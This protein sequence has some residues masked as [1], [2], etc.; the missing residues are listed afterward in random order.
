VWHGEAHALRQLPDDDDSLKTLDVEKPWHQK[1]VV[2][3]GICD[4]KYKRDEPRG[5]RVKVL[6]LGDGRFSR[7]SGHG[8]IIKTNFERCYS[9][10]NMLDRRL[11]VGNKK[12]TH[13]AFHLCGYKQ[14][15]P[16]Q[17]CFRRDYTRDLHTQIAKALGISD[18]GNAEVVL[19]LLNRC[20]GAGVIVSRTGSELDSN[21][22]M[23][24]EPP[25]GFSCDVADQFTERQLD[26]A[27]SSVANSMREHCLHWW[28]NECPVFIA[29][30]CA[31]SHPVAKEDSCKLY[32]GTL[33]VGFVLLGSRHGKSSCAHGV[34]SGGFWKPAASNLDIEFLGGYWKLPSESISSSD[35][36]GRCVSKAKTGTETVDGVDLED[37][38]NVLRQPLLDVFSVTPG[39]DFAQAYSEDPLLESFMVAR[40]AAATPHYKQL[41]EMKLP[42]QDMLTPDSGKSCNDSIACKAVASH[43]ERQ[44]GC[45]AAC[46]GDWNSAVEKWETSIS[47]YSFNAT[48]EHLLGYYHLSNA[49]YSKAI[50]H[51]VRSLSLD[52]E[53][54]ATYVNLSGTF[55]VARKFG[56]AV[57]VAEVGLTRYPF[58]YQ[59]SYNL[60]IALVWQLRLEL[61]EKD[62]PLSVEWQDRKEELFLEWVGKARRATE[63]L[64]AARDQKESK[65]SS[66]LSH[67]DEIL[68]TLHKLV[69]RLQ[70]KQRFDTVVGMLQDL[71]TIAGWNLMSFRP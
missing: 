64:V 12:V 31:V 28:T 5:C 36:A 40:L 61:Q 33:R 58:A 62:W 38:Y 14:L 41:A 3:F 65:Q 35:I 26:K 13:D 68:T 55:L 19:K 21:L 47:Y 71:P 6:E 46:K 23:L 25:E 69:E 45:A 16:T 30:C 10:G 44:L 54:K 49:N 4:L 27:L 50:K 60:G 63:A 59:C 34:S 37:V 52:P 56:F 66:W 11:L 7:F 2:Y 15:Q 51:F 42:S 24:L 67:D 32:N 22:Q 53:F 29:E 48:A 43:T 39:Q 20:R 17:A 18:K 9:K 57:R 70:G 8:E 1:A